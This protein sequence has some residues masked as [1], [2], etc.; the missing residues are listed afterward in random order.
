MSL[1]FHN[2]LKSL[3]FTVTKFMSFDIKVTKAYFDNKVL[4]P[5]E[6]QLTQNALNA[7]AETL[8]CVFPQQV[9]TLLQKFSPG[10]L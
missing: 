4:I 10:L 8:Q 5:G 3:L 2:F 9:V 7:E 1:L 6:M